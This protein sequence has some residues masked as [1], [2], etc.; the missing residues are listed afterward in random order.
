MGARRE[1]S[2]DSLRFSWPSRRF[3]YL[4]NLASVNRG[5]DNIGPVPSADSWGGRA[6]TA[7]CP[8]LGLKQFQIRSL[9]RA[10]RPEPIEE[11]VR[12]QTCKDGCRGSDLEGSGCGCPI[13]QRQM[14]VAGMV[15]AD[16]FGYAW[17][18]GTFVGLNRYLD[19]A[20]GSRWPYF[21]RWGANPAFGPY[22]CLPSALPLSRSRAFPARPLSFLLL[23]RRPLRSD[24]PA[25]SAAPLRAGIFLG[26]C[27]CPKYRGI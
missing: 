16:D 8:F 5:A 15:H 27:Q 10:L 21:Q 20:K 1:I 4:L 18:W 9:R 23:E 3:Q 14:V 2:V 6:D 11:L 22:S 19:A 7:C 17:Q 13:L 25:P 12:F 24:D 26:Q